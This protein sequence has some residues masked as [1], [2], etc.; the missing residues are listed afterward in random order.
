MSFLS[1]DWAHNH[2]PVASAYER[3]I[4]TSLAQYTDDDGC[5]AYKSKDTLAENALCDPKTVQRV[6]R[7]LQDRRLIARGD[8]SVVSHFDPR[9]RP[10]VYD[11][12]IPYSW[13]S[14]A[15]W[16]KLNEE[17]ARKGRPP[18]RPEDRPELPPPPPKTKRADKGKAA[19]Q[20]R[21]K[22]LGPR[23]DSDT[24]EQDEQSRGDSQS[25]LAETGK[26]DTGTRGDSESP[27]SDDPRG[28]S[29]SLSGGTLS[30][31][32]GD[33]ESP[34]Y[35]KSLHDVNYVTSSDPFATAQGSAGSAGAAPAQ[36]SLDGMP[37]PTKPR[38][39]V[40]PAPQ[41]DDMPPPPTGTEPHNAQ[42]RIIARRYWAGVK[43]LD[44]PVP[45]D[46][47]QGRTTPFMKFVAMVEYRLKGGYSWREVEQALIDLL[48]QNRTFPTTAVLDPKLVEN[49]RRR[50]GNLAA[51]QTSR[52]GRPAPRVHVD[53]VDQAERNRV[54]AAFGEEWTG[55]HS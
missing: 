5:N 47:G 8:Q 32:R 24:S 15:Q 53:S 42:A 20:R 1:Q 2:A 44:V 13:Y 27:L 40:V 41:P 35:V 34:N 12:M 14:K 23:P 4:I 50:N 21:P 33:S 16:L 17:R 46:D 10:V 28:D 52:Y 18:L 7:D 30:P 49:R 45:A 37:E 48:D 31:S 11:I 36:Q 55:G 39:T 26:M 6:L 25:P 9:Y 22:S 54:A 38:L 29:Q 3:C 19:P 43:R 51:P